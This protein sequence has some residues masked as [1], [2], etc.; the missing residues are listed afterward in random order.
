MIKEEY[1]NERKSWNIFGKI[2]EIMLIHRGN[3]QELAVVGLGVVF[4][5][6]TSVVIGADILSVVIGGVVVIVVVVVVVVPRVGGDV[7]SSGAIGV[8]VVTMND[9]GSVRLRHSSVKS[10][11]RLQ[12]A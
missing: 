1:F 4:A 7:A 6:V 9:G 8:G 5:F 11:I 12:S 2:L 3:F 10:S